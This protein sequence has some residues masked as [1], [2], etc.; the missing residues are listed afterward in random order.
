M[1]GERFG[2]D[3]I[4][5]NANEILNDAHISA[6]IIA[7]RH[8]SHAELVLNALE[9]KKA[10]HVEKPLAMTW[11]EIDTIVKAYQN[12]ETKPF[13]LVGFNRR[14]AP[15]IVEMKKF[16]SGCVESPI[17][18]I[19]VNAGYIPLGNWVQDMEQ[20][21]G[22]IVGEV[23]HFI[24]LAQFLAGSIVRSVY[25]RALPNG[26]K[27]RDDNVAITLEM[28]NGA[29]A[30]VLYVANGDRGLGKERIEM[31]SAG[32]IAIMD[33]YQCLEKISN[34]KHKISKQGAR[35]KGH[36]QEMEKWVQA[37]LNGNDEPVPFLEAVVATKASLAVI[38]TL[39]TGIPFILS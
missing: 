33:D 26:E 23:C 30:N 15:M 39:H 20:G 22:R 29:V 35:D 10:I 19:R 32:Q 25:A 21:G 14:F 36:R 24:D 5:Q 8:N 16:F 12:Q 27:Y 11:E 18:Q 17:I 1:W 3:Y 28:E 6:V 31:F 38:Q 34:G 4:S 13:V 37:I 9:S 7:T 2:F